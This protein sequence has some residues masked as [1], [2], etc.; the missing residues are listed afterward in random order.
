MFSVWQ[1][2][3]RAHDETILHHRLNTASAQKNLWGESCYDNIDSG[4]Q[5][6]P[7]CAMRAEIQRTAADCWRQFGRGHAC[8]HAEERAFTSVVTDLWCIAF[9]QTA[10]CHLCLKND[11]LV[12]FFLGGGVVPYLYTYTLETRLRLELF[13]V[14]WTGGLPTERSVAVPDNCSIV[15]IYRGTGMCESY[16]KQQKRKKSWQHGNN[17]VF[18][19]F[20]TNSQ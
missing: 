1:S 16:K 8:H 11:Q 18:F 2:Q 7:C 4:S 3:Q 9:T 17:E 10:C 5:P 6:L 19:F 13:P 12:F 15:F 20:N 14:K